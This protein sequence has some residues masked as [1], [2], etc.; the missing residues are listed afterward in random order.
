GDRLDT[1]DL[2]AKVNHY[3]PAL[4]AL[5]LASPFFR[6][7]LW[8]IRGR[9]G[10][11][12][13]TYRRSVLAPAIQLHPEE[14]RRL[15]YKTFEMTTSVSAFNAY[16]LLWLTLLLDDGLKGRASHQTRI[17]DLGAVARD[18][19]SAETVAER[20]AEVLERAPAVLSKWGFDPEPL[21]RFRERLRTK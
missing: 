14:R 2:H 8:R 5:T 15:E 19:L 11:S 4:T 12:V 10:P 7:E 1:S 21:K 3:S 17:Y 6:G 16:F 20:A 18:G 9:V 13:R